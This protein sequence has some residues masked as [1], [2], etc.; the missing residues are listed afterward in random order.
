M[1]SIYGNGR[2]L[3]GGTFPKER[4]FYVGLEIFFLGRIFRRKRELSGGGIVSGIVFR[5]IFFQIFLIIYAIVIKMRGESYTGKFP[6]RRG[7]FVLDFFFD[8]G[9]NKRRIR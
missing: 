6:W 9:S 4:E 2:K 8:D 7:K 1:F 3:F 5:E